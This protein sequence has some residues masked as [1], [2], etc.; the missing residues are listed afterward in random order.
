MSDR[1]LA[2]H[3]ADHAVQVVTR[4]EVGQEV[5][6]F[7]QHGVPVGAV[8]VGCIEVIAVDSPGL[9]K[10]LSPFRFGIDL[11]RDQIEF[12]RTV[13]LVELAGVDDSQHKGSARWRRPTGC[14]QDLLAIGR[15]LKLVDSLRERLLLA[16][17]EI[18]PLQG[19]LAARGRPLGRTSSDAPYV[20]DLAI[21]AGR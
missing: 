2:Q 14:V 4:G 16:G 3:H 9:V 10:H 12:E 15:D 1:Q 7:A 18:E 6:I 20:I 8:H 17:F 21:A 11:H 19:R 13:A 5:F